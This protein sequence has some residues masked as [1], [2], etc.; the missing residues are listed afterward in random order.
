MKLDVRNPQVTASLASTRI[1]RRQRMLGAALI[2]LLFSLAWFAAPDGQSHA[3]WQ[4][5]FGRFH[6]VAVHL[7]IALILLVPVLE[8][9]GR[10]RPALREAATLVLGLSVLA[11]IGA[12]I[13]GILLAHGGGFTRAAVTRHMWS[14]L[15][16]S[17]GVFACYCLRPYWASGR[18]AFLYPALLFCVVLLVA[19]TGH[20]G[21]SLTYGSG[22]LTEHLAGTL[23]L[24]SSNQAA[25][26]GSV[27]AVKIQPV[28]DANCL[29]CHGASKVKGGL[30]LD[31]FARLMRGGQDG[32]VISAGKPEQSLLYERITLPP[33]HEKF[34]PQEAKPLSAE[35]IQWIKEWIRQGASPSATELAGLKMPAVRINDPIPQVGDY[36]ALAAQMVQIQKMLGIRLDPVSRKPADG[37]ILRTIDVAPSFGDAQLAQLTPFAPYIVDAELGRTKVTD[38]SF[39]TLAKFSNVSAIH[40]E[41]TAITGQGLSKLSQLKHLNYLNLSGTQVTQAA[42][43]QAAALKPLHHLYLYNTPAQPAAAAAR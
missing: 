30:R 2:L 12:A 36:S 4:Q 37:L 1:A 34:M 40:L 35:S 8:L 27:Y 6:P 15:W 17:A 18:D 33:D 16:L 9:A 21:G 26:P 7:P 42:L 13:L 20:Q 32:A 19:W 22:Y 31:S 23:H 39:E 28:F 24:A 5:F 14:G 3:E 43:S 29:S 25:V 38:A 10:A 41:G 11:S